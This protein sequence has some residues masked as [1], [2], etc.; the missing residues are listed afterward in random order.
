MLWVIS[1]VLLF[2]ALQRITFEYCTRTA[3][4]L[5]G[6]NGKKVPKCAA[7][8]IRIKTLTLPDEF[9]AFCQRVHVKSAKLLLSVVDP[10][11]DSTFRII[12]YPAI[13]QHTRTLFLKLRLIKA[14]V[15]CR[16]RFFSNLKL[17]TGF[18]VFKK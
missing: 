16:L 12:L 2:G 13:M 1:E 4:P 8:Q 15:E 6:S 3:V 7:L 10:V 9:S 11:P 14:F 5:M 18:L 17:F